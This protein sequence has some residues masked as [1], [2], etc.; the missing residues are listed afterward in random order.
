[1]ARSTE[2]GLGAVQGRSAF[3]VSSVDLPAIPGI[4]DGTGRHVD[5]RWC[6]VPSTVPGTGQLAFEAK[7]CGVTCLLFALAENVVPNWFGVAIPDGLTDFS[8]VTVFFHPSPSQGGT[9]GYKDSDYPTKTGL[10]PNLFYYMELLGYQL[11]ASDRAQ[12]LV[13]PFLTSGASNAGILPA[14]WQ[15]ILPEVLGQARAKVGAGDGSPVT[16][17]NVAIASFSVGIVYMMAFRDHGV[18]LSA[19]LREIWDFDGVVSSAGSLSTGLASTPAVTAIKYDEIS[20]TSAG[21][22]HLPTA[23]WADRPAGGPTSVHHWIVDYMYRH[24]A[25]VSGVGGTLSAAAPGGGPVAPGVPVGTGVPAPPGVPV[26]TGV[27]V[28]PG[29]P[30]GT[31]V[32]VPPGVPVGP[33]V[34][35]DT[36]VPF[37][38]GVVP[39]DSG[40]LPVSPA[41][42]GGAPVTA[43]P[44]IPPA[45]PPTEPSVPGVAPQQP[46]AVGTRPPPTPAG[47]GGDCST[48]AVAIVASVSTVAVSAIT[49]ITALSA[50][51][52]RAPA[53]APDPPVLRH[54][55]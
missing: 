15:D 12:V 52:G 25:S 49:A 8:N 33:G 51:R 21:I 32:P 11:A 26:G 22:Y 23:R 16:I 14:S 18:G 44:T 38:T 46:A 53:P 36:T 5:S 42:P 6:V 50:R 37:G 13:M 2:S 54:P 47:P 41:Q 39:P 43:P 17:A 31:G 34:P 4:H 40:G 24:A 55:D 10:W 20:S 9:T 19:S 1:M 28:P 48:P 3:T 35:I 7:Q 27:A 45:L 30:V 29:V